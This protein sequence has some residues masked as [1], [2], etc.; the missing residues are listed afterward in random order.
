MISRLDFYFPTG[1]RKMLPVAKQA[2]CHSN[3]FFTPILINVI[4]MLPHYILEWFDLT[5]NTILNPQVSKIPSISDEQLAQIANDADKERDKLQSH[6]R[7]QVFAITSR[8]EIELFIRQYHSALIILLDRAHANCDLASSGNIVV[9]QACKTLVNC[10]DDLLGFIETHY[11][12]FL[13]LD[14]RVP[15]TYLSVLRAEIKQRLDALRIKLHRRIADKTLSELV[16]K[17]LYEFTDGSSGRK[18]T[19]REMLYRKELVKGLEELLTRPERNVNKA[20]NALLIYRNFNKKAYLEYYTR[21]IVEKVNRCSSLTQ[22]MEELFLA[23]KEF[24][25]MHRKT[26]VKLN[27]HYADVKEVIGNWFVE[28]INFLEK[29][30]QF[31]IN[32]AE[33]MPRVNSEKAASKIRLALNSDQIAILLRAAVDVGMLYIR[34]VHFVFKTVVPFLASTKEENLSWDSL[35]KRS[36]QAENKDKVIVIAILEKAIAY[37][38]TY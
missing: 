11:A 5:I 22:K 10:L 34:S 24:N 8:A 36:Y 23:Y 12:H 25:Q 31:Q 18:V 6:L 13:G 2:F 16:F 37:V 33:Q 4:I 27:P 3:D 29:K 19:F 15:V 7:G 30:Y 1:L 9:R 32:P 35:R 20:L 17:T 21:K 38:Q 28:E 14:E 26:G